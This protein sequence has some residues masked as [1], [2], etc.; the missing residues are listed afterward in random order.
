MKFEINTKTHLIVNKV[1]RPLDHPIV[2][3]EEEDESLD[4]IFLD[5]YGKEL[6]AYLN[7]DDTFYLA[8]AKRPHEKIIIYS[9]DFEIISGN[10]LHFNYTSYTE[11]YLEQITQPKEEVLI[12]IGRKKAGQEL[13]TIE[14]QQ[15]IWAKQRVKRELDPQPI[16]VDAYYTKSEVDSLLAGKQDKITSDNKLDYSLLSATPTIPTKTSELTND[17]DFTTA[18]EVATAINTATSGKADTAY[19]DSLLAEK[20]PLITEDAKLDA[21]LVSGLMPGGSSTWGEISGT[22]SAQQDLQEKLDE[23]KDKLVYT[24]D[25]DEIADELEKISELIEEKF[26]GG[27]YVENIGN[28]LATVKFFKSDPDAEIKLFYSPYNTW[29][30]GMWWDD[31]GYSPTFNLN[32]GDVFFFYGD[33]QAFSTEN[34]KVY[35]RGTGRLR[36]WGYIDLLLSPRFEERSLPNYCF[37]ELFSDQ[38]SIEEA[39]ITL[40]DYS[41]GEYSLSKLFFG[42]TNLKKAIITTNHGGYRSLE[43]M[44]EGCTS[45]SDITATF[46]SWDDVD[47]TAW[48][49]GVAPSGMFR[50][51]PSLSDEHGIDRIPQG[52]TKTVIDF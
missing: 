9:Q 30:D 20:Q 35:F 42:C 46:S 31:N 22:L 16:P 21:N 33:N 25:H 8:V 51:W 26:F 48:V 15:T 37:A 12:E 11:E 43:R 39:D 47:T 18:G 13:Y 44:F 6:S 29:S 5:E 7:P 28:E 32:P 3:Q 45:L 23:K 50:C 19:V 40:I 4:L 27:F 1:N 41:S 52:W 2:I 17:S 14:L 49:S 24:S 36:V 34:A 38:D 10:Q